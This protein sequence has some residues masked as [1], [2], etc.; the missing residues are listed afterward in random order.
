MEMNGSIC[1]HLSVSYDARS[2]TIPQSR[3]IC[4]QRITWVTDSKHDPYA[5]LMSPVKEC[6]DLRITFVCDLYTF[7]M[8]F[9][10][11]LIPARSRWMNRDAQNFGIAL[12]IVE[13]QP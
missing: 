4:S 1:G 13:R 11:S 7:L 8:R 12:R 2:K 6:E 3:L 9:G 10:M 5:F